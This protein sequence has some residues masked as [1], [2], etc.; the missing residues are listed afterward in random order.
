MYR[1]IKFPVIRM[2]IGGQ[3]KVIGGQND[4][5]SEIEYKEKT[6]IIPFDRCGIPM[7][8]EELKENINNLTEALEHISKDDYITFYDKCLESVNKEYIYESTYSDLERIAERNEEKKQA[9]NKFDSNISKPI[10]SENKIETI[11]K[12]MISFPSNFVDTKEVKYPLIIN[13][14]KDDIL[15]KTGKCFKDLM[16]TI[17][18]TKNKYDFDTYSYS[19]VPEEYIDQINEYIILFK[20]PTF[21]TVRSLKKYIVYSP[22]RSIQKR[23]NFDGNGNYLIR[24]DR[25]IKILN[26]NNIPYFERDDRIFTNARLALVKIGDY[27]SGIKKT[28]PSPV[29]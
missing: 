14:Y 20:N 25:I 27:L 1:C 16:I 23:I 26:Q 10:L 9:I 15:I 17:N 29:K 3:K 22:I 2:L 7:E 19:H 21:S 13:F 11:L 4:I 24:K 12:N 18:N 5:F 8:Y 28:G 6:Y